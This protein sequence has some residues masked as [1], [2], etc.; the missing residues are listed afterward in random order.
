MVTP[1]GLDVPVTVSVTQDALAGVQRQL[2][3][4]LTRLSDGSARASALAQQTA[5]RADAAAHFHAR[6]EAWRH[7]V[8]SATDAV[9][10]LRDAV[11]SLRARLDAEAWR[12]GL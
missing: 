8:S 9:E 12:Y 10:G 5:W 1:A 11:G 6:A 2:H 3:A 7:D 4:A